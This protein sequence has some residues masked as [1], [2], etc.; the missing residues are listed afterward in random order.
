MRL[1][2]VTDRWGSGAGFFVDYKIA[3]SAKRLPETA[4]IPIDCEG[5]KIRGVE[6]GEGG[7]MF[8]HRDGWITMLECYGHGEGWPEDTYDFEFYQEASN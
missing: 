3:P 6:T 7:G 2:T 1:A 8:F 5:F 4:P